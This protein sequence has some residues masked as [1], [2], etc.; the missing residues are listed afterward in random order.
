MARPIGARQWEPEADGSRRQ[1]PR[2]GRPG[3]RPPRR[4]AVPS[5]RRLV[6]PVVLLLIAGA[7]I[8][9]LGDLARAVQQ[10]GASSSPRPS[11]TAAAEL[12]THDGGTGAAATSSTLPDAGPSTLP[13]T[14]I[15]TPRATSPSPE[16][17]PSAE[18]SP[19]RPPGAAPASAEEF[20]TSA[21]VVIGI[22]FPFKAG[23]RYRYRDNWLHPRDGDPESYN[24]V[25]LPR[26]GQPVRAHDGIDVY[27]PHGT[28]VLAP[29]AGLVIDPAE[30]WQP[31]HADRY[32]STVVIVSHEPLSAGY[33]ALLSHLDA[34]LVEPGTVV[35]R[36]EVVGLNGNSGNAEDSAAHLHFELRAPFELEWSEAGSKRLVDAFNPYPSLV[37]ADTREDD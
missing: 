17:S 21:D 27:A 20:D 33:V 28:P 9:L 5:P 13:P 8:A 26:R 15:Q 11:A 4:R 3:E 34:A 30:R 32:G 36:G 14:S 23:A 18:P 6:G 1:R 10:T 35:R 22:E 37:A 29:F 19:T 31:W 24:H 16:P 7:A 12:R 25:R 2:A